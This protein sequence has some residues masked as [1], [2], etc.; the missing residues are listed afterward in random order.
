MKRLAVE[1]AYHDSVTLMLASRDAEAVD[2][3]DFAA[4]VAATPVN[5]ELLVGQGFDVPDGLGPDDM[6]VALDGTEEA[7][8][9]A[10][11]AISARLTAK[12][13]AGGGD[14]IE[15]PRSLR[16][17]A[18]R[19]PELNLAL[20][21]T[22]GRYAA[23]ESASAL[24]AGLN[25]FCFSDGVS[26]EAEVALKERAHELGLLMM[27][28]DCGTA[29]VAGTGL[30]FANVVPSGPVGIV[31]ASG[32]GTQ[33]VSCLLARAGVGI[34][35][36]IGVGGRDL[37]AEVGARMTLDAIELLAHDAAT[38]VIVVVSKPP[39]PE[40]EPVV[41][42]AA[43]A[44]GKPVVMALLGGDASSEERVEVVSS[45]EEAAV[46]AAALAGSR[47]E[48]P[49]VDI[50]RTPGRVV[51]LF[52]GGTLCSEAQRIVAAA[53][54][55]HDFTDYG[56]DEMTTGRPHPMIDPTLRNEAFVRAAADPAV[57]VVVLDVV[58]GH[59]AHAD[60]AAELAPLIA[61]AL[62]QRS[63]GVSVV[64]TVCGTDADPQG[65]AGQCTVL[66]EA[67]AAVTVSASRAAELAVEAAR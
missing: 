66:E 33:E 9:D 61:A 29:I 12:P 43:Q 7:L 58:L 6:I 25:V 19:D 32:T 36:A 45:L 11:A 17:A 26:L 21:S 31:G 41:M 24:E 47:L 27:G 40:V 59:G 60:P 46:R 16:A 51:G 18:G 37:Q 3:I 65:L 55:E 56:D 38:E 35:H 53:G 2:G 28:P 13:A 64:V 1:R 23:Y 62:A 42:E 20:V 50:G 22:P 54:A 5:L 48:V 4:A 52:S 30:G 57:G 67:G 15:A 49:V 63:G 8:D 39:A 10:A 34:S 44:C 14:G